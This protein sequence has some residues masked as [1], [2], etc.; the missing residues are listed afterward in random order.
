MPGRTHDRLSGG[1]AE[2]HLRADLDQL[3][4]LAAAAGQR[5][6]SPPGFAARSGV[7]ALPYM[8]VD[9][10]VQP[11]PTLNPGAVENSRAETSTN[12]CRP[13]RWSVARLPTGPINTLRDTLFTDSSIRVIRAIRGWIELRN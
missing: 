5:V 7:R 10:A 4:N 1:W 9:H 12:H 2:P 13:D 3:V 8:I 11:W 6:P